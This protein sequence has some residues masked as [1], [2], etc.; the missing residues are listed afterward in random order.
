MAP[1]LN[2]SS[3]EHSVMRPSLLPGLLQVL[4]HNFSRQNHAISGFEIGRVHLCQGDR[5]EEP[6]LIGIIMSGLSRPPHWDIKPLPVDFY[7]L[8]GM[9][10]NLLRSL[11]I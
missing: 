6:T 10:E 1:L 11:G 3:A 4:K 5:F 2:P 7:D 9:L 8:K